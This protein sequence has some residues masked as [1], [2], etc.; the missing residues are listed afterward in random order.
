[1]M[2]PI[3]TAARPLTSGQQLVIGLEAEDFYSGLLSARVEEVDDES[4][5]EHVRIRLICPDHPAW[6]GMSINLLVTH[7]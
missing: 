7:Q 5:L 1:M 4:D 2:A 3:G 6:D